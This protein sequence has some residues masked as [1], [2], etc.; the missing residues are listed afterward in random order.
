MSYRDD[1]T[2]RRDYQRAYYAAHRDALRARH[3]AHYATHRDA[4]CTAM[5][6]YGSSHQAEQREYKLRYRALHGDEERARDRRYSSTHRPQAVLRAREWARRNPERYL[7]HQR[8]HRARKAAAQGNLTAAEW[9]SIKAAYSHACAYCRRGDVK[10]TQ[11]HVLPL[12]GGGAHA[13]GNVVPACRSCNSKKGHRAP[14][15]PVALVLI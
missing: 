12:V 3:A 9:E 10:L 6:L 1:P 7:A 13:I 14:P 2:V 5:R 15:R 11:D 8:R 4:L